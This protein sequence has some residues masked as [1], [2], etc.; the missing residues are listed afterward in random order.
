MYLLVLGIAEEFG[1][2]LKALLFGSPSDV[3]HLK[4]Q[5]LDGFSAKFFRL[6]IFQSFQDEIIDHN[7]L[8][9]IGFQNID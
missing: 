6:F 3:S 1:Q 7:I 9:W 4:S 8:L 5:D 2:F